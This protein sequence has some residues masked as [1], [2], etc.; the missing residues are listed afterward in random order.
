MSRY[1]RKDYREIANVIK[2]LRERY[3]TK[4]DGIE[5][6]DDVAKSLAGLFK[7]D[8]PRFDAKRFYNAC[9]K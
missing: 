5:A 6:L 9:N 4:L 8:N 2:S 7:V 3:D 1:S